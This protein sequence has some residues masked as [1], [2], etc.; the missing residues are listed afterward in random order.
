MMQINTQQRNRAQSDA[1]QRRKRAIAANTA[2]WNPATERVPELEIKNWSWPIDVSR[3]D[4]RSALTSSEAAFLVEYAD[5][6]LRDQHA[7]TPAFDGWI[8][9]LVKPIEDVFEYIRFRPY[10]RPWTINYILRETKNRGRS[11]W[12]WS[13]EE[14]IDTIN[15]RG[16]DR[17]SILAVAYLLC[18]FSDVHRLGGDRIIYI[19]FARKLFG[20]SYVVNLLKRARECLTEWGYLYQ[21]TRNHV[22]RLLCQALIQNRSPRLH[23][24]TMEFL[25]QVASTTTDDCR[26]SVV[27]LACVLNTLIGFESFLAMFG[28][29]PLSPQFGRRRLR[30][31]PANG[32]CSV[33]AGSIRQPIHYP[34][35]VT[36]TT[37]C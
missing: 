28:S 6:Y 24:L 25:D 22:C 14:W 16:N 36:S 1:E 8:D 17:Q 30:K 35:A 32:R 19:V 5:S 21:A 2:L 9:R 12:G 34:P 33:I 27:A 7:R 10:C 29:A 4:R 18:D 15:R 23:D 20:T 13:R 31:C 11:I 26:R 3:Y 37:H